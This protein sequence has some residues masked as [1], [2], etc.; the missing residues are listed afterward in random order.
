MTPDMTPDVHNPSALEQ[1]ITAKKGESL[2]ERQEDLREAAAAG[3]IGQ[4]I[5]Q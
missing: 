1:W 3:R 2:Q 4:A 5:V